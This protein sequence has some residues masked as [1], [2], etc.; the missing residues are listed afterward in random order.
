[1][2]QI[3]KSVFRDLLT[4]Q[5][6]K[7]LQGPP[8]DTELAARIVH[9][10]AHLGALTVGRRAA[11]PKE[12]V[13]LTSEIEMSKFCSDFPRVHGWARVLASAASLARH[14]SRDHTSQH[15]SEP[16]AKLPDAGWIYSASEHLP[17]QWEENKESKASTWDADMTAA[18]DSLLQALACN[19]VL[20]DAPWLDALR[21][22]L[23]ALSAS[24]DVPFVA[25]LILYWS[26][27]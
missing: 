12:V 22:I 19:G 16:D 2:V 27:H 7:A 10:T 6:F 15:L 4:A 11:L 1:M 26:P 21:V 8:I 5:L 9:T 24:G 20:Y 18:V 3:N 25:F 23:G 14:A 17:H 13:D